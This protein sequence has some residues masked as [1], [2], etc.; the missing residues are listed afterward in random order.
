MDLDQQDI[1]SGVVVPEL[2]KVGERLTSK[3]LETLKGQL[4]TFTTK[5]AEADRKKKQRQEAIVG[6]F[7]PLPL[8]NHSTHDPTRESPSR[9]PSDSCS[10][11][12]DN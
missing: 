8:Y 12:S 7:P 9:Y 6:Q 2:P 11:A 4:E 5:I 1:P 10:T 3:Q